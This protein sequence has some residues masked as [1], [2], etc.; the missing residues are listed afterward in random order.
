MQFLKGINSSTLIYTSHGLLCSLGCAKRCLET[1]LIKLKLKNTRALNMGSLKKET[2]AYQLKT[3]TITISR[4]LR[5][6]KFTK[7]KIH[8]TS[9]KSSIITT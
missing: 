8:T 2:K 9:D 5:V 1:L 7:Q 3:Q 4:F 6:F